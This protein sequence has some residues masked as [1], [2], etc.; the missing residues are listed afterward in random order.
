LT[1][2]RRVVAV[3]LAAGSSTRFGSDKLLHPFHGRPLGENIALTLLDVPLAARLAVCP[4][5]NSAR[6]E[7]FIRHHFE[8]IDNPQPEQGMGISLAL[9]AQRAIDLDADALLV[10]LAD[11]PNV[12]VEHL[13]ALLGL[14][15]RVA[16]T[17]TDNTRSPPAV[18]ARELLPRLTSLTGDHGA[19]HL[20]KSAATVTATPDLMRD[21][22]TPADFA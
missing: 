14:N 22:D 19:R 13:M 12:T 5:E 4:V 6:R 9:G 15:A 3:I 18:F 21:F 10:C 17:E 16:V 8:I 1:A 20:L 11:M 7:L 2:A